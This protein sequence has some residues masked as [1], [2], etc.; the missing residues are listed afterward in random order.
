MPITRSRIAATAATTTLPIMVADTIS[1]LP[2]LTTADEPPPLYSWS[3]NRLERVVGDCLR[4]AR[5]AVG[6][7]S[8][9]GGWMWW[10]DTQR[11]LHWIRVH[12]GQR[13]IQ[14]HNRRH[15]QMGVYESA[16]G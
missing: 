14:H 5:G 10:T 9:V 4:A 13:R 8:V 11:H 3:A 16:R 7:E 6:A 1:T 15:C 12:A 2:S